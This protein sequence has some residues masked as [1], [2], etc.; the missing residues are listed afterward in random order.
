MSQLTSNLWKFIYKYLKKIEF[1]KYIHF[2]VFSECVQTWLNLRD[3]WNINLFHFSSPIFKLPIKFHHQCS[4]TGTDM[5]KT[6]W[7]ILKGGMFTEIQ[8]DSVKAEHKLQH[9]NPTPSS[10]TPLQCLSNLA[11]RLFYSSLNF[12]PSFFG[13]H[14]HVLFLWFFIKLKN[15]SSDHRF[16]TAVS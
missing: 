3:F 5:A 1:W 9:E 14:Y 16:N 15:S 13:F 2:F 10:K 8:P 12:S 4:A 7:F 11:S 6:H